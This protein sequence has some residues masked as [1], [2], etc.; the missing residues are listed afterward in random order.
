[1]KSGIKISSLSIPLIVIHDI[2]ALNTPIFSSL[3]STFSETC[4]PVKYGFPH[5]SL[6]QAEMN[7]FYLNIFYV[8]DFVCLFYDCR[9]S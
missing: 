1:M 8:F 2:N 6:L 9:F 4:V 7:N 3:T 5:V